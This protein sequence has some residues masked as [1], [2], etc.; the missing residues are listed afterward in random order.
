MGFAKRQPGERHARYFFGRSVAD[1]KE[2]GSSWL[3]FASI[4]TRIP[5][6]LGLN[7]PCNLS[8]KAVFFVAM[9]FPGGR[10][11]Y[12]KTNP[13]YWKAV[14][15]HRSKPTCASPVRHPLCN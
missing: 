11:R 8:A 7:F 6:V 5:D 1:F 4:N 13:K 9:L 3:F 10:L 12:S 15:C 2:N 14:P